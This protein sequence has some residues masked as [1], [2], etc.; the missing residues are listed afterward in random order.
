MELDEKLT[1]KWTAA[2]YAKG[3]E[4][5][6]NKLYWTITG[7]KRNY[8]KFAWQWLNTV[9]GP[10]TMWVIKDSE[11]GN[12]V[13]HHGLVP[14]KLSYFGRPLL[15]GMTENTM[16]HPKFK[17]KNLYFPFEKQFIEEDLDDRYDLLLT[18]AS[19]GSQGRVRARLG[20]TIFDNWCHHV[21]FLT[22]KGMVSAI[23]D[24]M[25]RKKFGKFLTAVTTG[26]AAPIGHVMFMPN[27]RLN[28]YNDIILEAFDFKKGE[29][30]QIDH[31]LDKNRDSYEITAWRSGK[32]LKW[33]LHDNPYINGSLLV[34]KAKKEILGYMAWR[35]GAAGAHWGRT[36]EIIDIYVTGFSL[37]LLQKILCIGSDFLQKQGYDVVFFKT[38]QSNLRIQEILLKAGFIGPN[39][40]IPLPM[41]SGSKWMIKIINS[42]LDVK[43]VFNLQKWFVTPI[44]SEGVWWGN[45]I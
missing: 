21:K 6:L 12:V 40:L 23:Q 39:F 20:Y 10:S 45:E 30:A 44:F 2:S 17:G 32:L 37:D 11:T 15:L 14:L 7:R 9:D 33:W 13:G 1:G 31:F 35:P 27:F 38:L 26:L 34:A 25:L 22:K 41:L 29:L 19:N 5:G 3:D 16:I 24:Y 36:A 42:E 18:R 4:K 28:K 43:T 8:A